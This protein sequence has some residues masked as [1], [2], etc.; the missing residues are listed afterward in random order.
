ISRS[1]RYR[2][3]GGK[4]AIAIGF[5]S[6]SLTASSSKVSFILMS[7]SSDRRFITGG[8]M[9][10]AIRLGRWPLVDWNKLKT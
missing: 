5:L 3:L 7:G 10:Y 9:S 1:S 2:I 4:K 8:L 6:A